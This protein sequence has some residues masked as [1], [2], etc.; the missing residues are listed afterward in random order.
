MA[1][2]K[3]TIT[4]DDEQVL[5][6]RNLVTAGRA[7]SV[8]G[9]VQHAVGVA[10]DEARLSRLIRQPTRDVV[11]LD[12][13]DAVNVGR[14]LSSSGTSDVVDAHVVVCARRS[15]QRVVT[16]DPTDLSLLDRTLELIIV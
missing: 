14:L 4:L 15:A 7:T 1:S 12:R 10:I 9:F 2:K 3:I 5:Q 6:I 13:V 11:P 8:S 16:S